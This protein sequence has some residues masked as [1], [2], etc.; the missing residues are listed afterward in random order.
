MPELSTRLPFLPDKVS[1]KVQIAVTSVGGKEKEQSV[2]TT[3]NVS[4]VDQFRLIA[5]SF[6]TCMQILWEYAHEVG[7][8]AERTFLSN[9]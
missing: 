3:A 7:A 8:V 9:L 2:E 4:S 1:C 5:Q 6:V